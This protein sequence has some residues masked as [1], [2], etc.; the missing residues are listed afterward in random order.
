MDSTSMRNR[1]SV[2]HAPSSLL[3]IPAYQ[4]FPVIATEASAS[5]G[6]RRIT[7][8]PTYHVDARHSSKVPLLNTTTAEKH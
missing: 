6:M 2:E 1:A 3:A 7:H 8:G 5:S 4:A